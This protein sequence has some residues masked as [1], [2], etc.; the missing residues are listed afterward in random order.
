[1]KTKTK[2][3]NFAVLGAILALSAGLG[4][5][6]TTKKDTADYAYSGAGERAPAQATPALLTFVE[7]LA[8]NSTYGREAAEQKIL[9]VIAAN[10][11]KW[12]IPAARN[13]N[14]TTLRNA[15]R[16]VLTAEEEE[17][18]LKNLK[19]ST[20]FSKTVRVKQ[21]DII[22]AYNASSK[23][24]EV[25]GSSTVGKG[26]NLK[27]FEL[28]PMGVK[29]GLSSDVD[30][31]ISRVKRPDVRNVLV[32]AAKQHLKISADHPELKAVVEDIIKKS[33]EISAKTEMQVIGESGCIKAV[34]VEALDNFLE[35]LK[36][37]SIAVTNGEKVGPAFKTALA[38]VTEEEVPF[39]CA[40]RI[41]PLTKECNIVHTELYV[42]ACG[43]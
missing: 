35:S 42:A 16:N 29:T 22:S 13:L 6:S 15:D 14:S 25:M 27:G 24:A 5:C 39:V 8:R 4:A 18:I 17:I 21:T 23:S 31:A 40:N 38:K 3:K 1:M 10:A 36:R 30:L 32:A 26:A 7:T 11:E 34:D 28:P 2:L 37:T 33:A 12:G 9:A 43:K 19:N 41:E 20:T